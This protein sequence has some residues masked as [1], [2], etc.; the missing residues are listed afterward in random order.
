MEEK[1]TDLGAAS[2]VTRKLQYL[3]NTLIDE[4][5][6]Y[7]PL[8]TNTLFWRCCSKWISCLVTEVVDNN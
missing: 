8:N 6:F 4:L 1:L 2:E 7:A 5:K 3:C